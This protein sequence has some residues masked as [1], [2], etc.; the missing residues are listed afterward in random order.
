[1][2][3]SSLV[4]IA[5][6][7][8]TI[9]VVASIVIHAGLAVGM[10]ASGGLHGARGDVRATSQVLTIDIEPVPE[11]KE[12][13]TPLAPPSNAPAPATHTHDYP[14]A[15]SHDARPHDPGAL[16]PAAAPAPSPSPSAEEHDAPGPEVVAAPA[17]P[18]FVLS[19]GEARTTPSTTR[20]AG[21]GTNGAEDVTVLPVNAVDVPARL[22]ASAPLAY[23]PEARA[24]D[25]EADVAL[26]IVVDR[27]GHVTDARVVRPASTGFDAAA[28]AAVR[29]YRF[30]PARRQGAAVRVRMPW[31]VQFRLR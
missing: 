25:R 12:A 17:A 1:M 13:N 31:A 30:S 8:R 9:P 5:L 24:D 2:G 29:R 23:P 16:H 20:G 22:V 18:R 14:V 28:I 27:E 6:A 19:T 11:E 15:A 26:E 10:I 4:G 7:G 3:G 21:A